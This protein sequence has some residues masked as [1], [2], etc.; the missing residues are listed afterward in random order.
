MSREDLGD[1]PSTCHPLVDRETVSP[2]IKVCLF[3]AL[4]LLRFYWSQL[5]GCVCGVLVFLPTEAKWIR[6]NSF[7]LEKER[8]KNNLFQIGV[9]LKWL[10]TVF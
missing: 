4:L 2:M 8:K 7:L 5:D 6:V 9:F 1:L 3:E 10:I